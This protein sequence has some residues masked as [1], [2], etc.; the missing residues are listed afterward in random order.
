MSA[1]HALSVRIATHAPPHALRLDDW[2]YAPGHAGRLGGCDPWRP[3]FVHA[4][5]CDTDTHAKACASHLVCR[6]VHAVCAHGDLLARADMRICTCAHIFIVVDETTATRIRL[7][8]VHRPDADVFSKIYNI[9]SHRQLPYSLAVSMLRHL[10]H[11]VALVH[12]SAPLVT[13]LSAATFG[14][15]QHAL[16]DTWADDGREDA[17]V[18]SGLDLG[19]ACELTAPAPDVDEPACAVG[20]PPQTFETYDLSERA[21]LFDRFASPKRR[22]SDV[23]VEGAIRA[24]ERVEAS[25]WPDAIKA[26]ARRAIC[27]SAQSSRRPGAPITDADL[28]PESHL[29]WYDAACARHMLVT[30]ASPRRYS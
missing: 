11:G 17:P 9:R 6:I 28:I 8:V 19:E 30:D 24:L 29:V 4:T 18:S 1:G 7:V 2:L 10:R 27:I 15:F 26:C 22:H 25:A 21:E 3:N 16:D 13:F 20:T 23:T 12:A 14:A 5:L